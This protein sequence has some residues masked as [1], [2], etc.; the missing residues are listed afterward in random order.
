MQLPEPERAAEFFSAWL[1]RH[2]PLGPARDANLWLHDALLTAACDV[3]AAPAVR[4]LAI[5]TAGVPVVYSHK[6]SRTES[7]KFR[8]LIEPGGTAVT[9]AEQVRLSRNLLHRVVD[10]F[11]WQ[12]AGERVDAVLASLLPVDPVSF[13]DWHGGLGFGIEADVNGPELRLYCNARHG[14]LT[15]R[16]QRL[17]DAV[18]EFADE[19]AEGLFAQLLDIA[20]PRTVPAGVAVALAGGDVRAIRL[21][22]GLLEATSESVLAAAPAGFGRTADA[23]RRLVDSYCSCFGQLASQDITLAYDFAVREG[24]L[25]PSVARFKVDIW[26]EPANASRL[27]AWA[28]GYIDFLGRVPSTLREYFAELDRAFPGSTF[29]YV[30]LGCRNDS[31]EFSTYLIPGIPDPVTTPPPRPHRIAPG[32]AGVSAALVDTAVDNAVD[33]LLSRRGG[34]GWWTD[35]DTLAGP[36]TEWVSAFVALALAQTGRTA[37]LAAARETWRRLR[38]CRWW[39]PGWGYNGIVPSDADTTLWV[40]HLATAL[41]ER[42]SGR[43]LRFLARHVT[44][45]GGLATYAAA[46]PIRAFTGMTGTSFAGWCSPQA[47]VTAAGASVPHLPHRARLLEWLRAAQRPDGSWTSY[48][49]A[50]PHYATALASEAIGE[51]AGPGDANR[52]ARAARWTAADLGHW[53]ADAATPFEKA[54]ALRTLSLSQE[55]EATAARVLEQVLCDQRTDGSWPPSARLRIPPP[56]VTDPDAYA[57][58]VDGGRGG[59]SVQSDSHACFTTAAVLHALNA[60]GGPP[61]MRLKG[62]SAHG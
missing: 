57:A 27:L 61:P 58:W 52:I 46:G 42:G 1:A 29:Q 21:Y 25:L 60:A 2:C 8:M 11:G 23:I 9:V 48:W 32:V 47:C 31:P 45:S 37:A 55:T 14:D 26:C 6:L 50:S 12:R 28:D 3:A 54:F 59:G 41:G 36:S 22:A 38:R 30:S 39:S 40:L 15:S 10:H 43:T 5:T 17:I 24:T 44:A 56:D 35:F 20:V 53:A 16:W 13:G 51:A 19:R 18:A 62:L 33:S 7:P 34:D 4:P 49:W